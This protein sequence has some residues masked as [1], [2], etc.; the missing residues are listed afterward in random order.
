MGLE[1]NFHCIQHHGGGGSMGLSKNQRGGS[2]PDQVEQVERILS[3]QQSEKEKELPE[4]I[5]NNWFSR[6]EPKVKI[7]LIIAVAVLCGEAIYIYFSPFQTC[8]REGGDPIT[9]S[10][11]PR[12]R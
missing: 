1:N 9:C 6:Q 2:D 7:A 3:E 11:G 12:Y 4:S 5:T 10:F 8:M